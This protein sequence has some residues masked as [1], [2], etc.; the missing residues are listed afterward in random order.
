MSE[1]ERKELNYI[2]SLLRNAEVF[3]ITL[4]PEE[5]SLLVKYID[6]LRD[7]RGE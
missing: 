5:C 6:Y 3:N 1:E 7:L 4:S 2:M